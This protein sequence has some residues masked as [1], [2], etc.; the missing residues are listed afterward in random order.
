MRLWHYKLIPVLPRAQLVSQLREC[1]AI[2]KALYEKGTP[3][4]ILV[5]KV[6]NYSYDE[7]YSYCW[8]V[9]NELKK[10]GYKYRQAT[11]DKIELYLN[12]AERHFLGTY[13]ELFEGWHNVRYLIQCYYNLQ[14]KRDCGGI[15]EDEWKL[16]YD[17]SMSTLNDYC[18]G[19]DL[20]KV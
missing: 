3:N 2:A 7:F 6:T 17:Y 12:G 5:N 15:T 1:V 11:V 10:R 19:F 4:H 13:A 9:L 16:I 18:I 8:L 20:S 14:E